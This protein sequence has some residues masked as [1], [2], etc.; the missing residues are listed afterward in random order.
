[1][2]ELI[3]FGKKPVGRLIGVS[4]GATRRSRLRCRSY[5][6]SDMWMRS[7]GPSDGVG[8]LTGVFGSV[9]ASMDGVGGS[10]DVS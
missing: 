10:V 4:E 8:G 1:M 9:S 3:T 5:S 6:S 2:V 7:G